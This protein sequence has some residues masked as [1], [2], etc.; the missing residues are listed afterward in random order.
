[1][2]QPDDARAVAEVLEKYAEQ[3]ERDRRPAPESVAAVRAAGFFGL[4]GSGTDTRT[5]VEILRELGQACA[6][7]AWV[8]GLNIGAK[9]LL[10]RN[11]PAETRELLLA[12][13][14]VLV[15]GSGASRGVTARR[16]SDGLVISGR[17]QNCSGCEDA[18]YAML[19]VPLDGSVV[20][21]LADT[22]ELTVDRDWHIAGMA[23]SGSHTLVADEV[24]VPAGRI[25]FDMASWVATPGTQTGGVAAM[26]APL[27]G[28]TRGAWE[29]VRRVLDGGKA[30]Y[31]SRFARITDSAL[32]RFWFTEATHL[33]DSAEWHLRRVA[34]AVDAGR[35]TSVAER[36]ELR[37]HLST[38]AQQCRQ[39]VEKLLDL[40][41]MSGFTL[42][43]PLQRRWRD[44]AVGT[45]HPQFNPYLAEED[46][47]R[48]LLAAGEPMSTQL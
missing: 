24:L 35:V 36:A 4:A 41:G 34:E 39:A 13:P 47:G 9:E 3:T 6:S 31:G 15:C 48:V 30:P 25:Q 26:L 12:D 32:G 45:R 42:S 33:V 38:S 14:G 18:G 27:A 37:T 19:I 40:G 1:M 29:D 21:A 20:I 22:R 5:R 43:N 23:G 28:A 7:T 10:L 44:V 11:M 8:T 16:V 17:W 2:T 46:Y